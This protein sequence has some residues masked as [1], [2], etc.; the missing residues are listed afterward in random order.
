MRTRA[1]RIRE[2]GSMW[3]AD[4]VLGITGM[5]WKPAAEGRE[6]EDIEVVFNAVHREGTIFD[7]IVKKAPIG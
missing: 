1:M 5:P 2:K 4:A 3:N 6:V 7:G